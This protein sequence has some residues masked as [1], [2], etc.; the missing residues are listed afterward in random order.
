MANNALDQIQELQNSA[1]LNGVAPS[2]D[3]NF[4][5][6]NDI[7]GFRFEAQLGKCGMTAESI[8]HLGER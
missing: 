4:V 5:Y 1:K 3:C 2:T 7:D 6:D 8:V